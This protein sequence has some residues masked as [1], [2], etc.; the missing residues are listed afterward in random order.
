MSRSG[1]APG[2]TPLAR[3]GLG[4]VAATAGILALTLNDALGKLLG[5]GYDVWQIVFV[6]SLLGLAPIVL[7]VRHSGGLGAL[8]VRSPALHLLRVAC[9]TGS[10]YLFFAGLQH[11]PL[12][13]SLAITFA[14]PIFV[15]ALSGRCWASA[16][17]RGAGP[18][19]WWASPA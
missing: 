9:A 15:T 17:E 11:L 3:V 16:W 18:W 8:R 1:P 2:D 6:R 5:G 7:I 12:T 10:A 19:C 14:A 13:E 4:V